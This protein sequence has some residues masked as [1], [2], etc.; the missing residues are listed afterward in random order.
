MGCCDKTR[1]FGT[2]IAHIVQ[3]NARWALGIKYEF[4]DDRVRICQRCE[5]NYWIGRSLWCS[6]C[7]CH[8]PAK[9]RIKEE[10]CPL[11]KW[12]AA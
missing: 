12:P 8:V 1:R 10:N 6:I 2:K 4:T 9:A 5:D 11:G 3:G 7:K